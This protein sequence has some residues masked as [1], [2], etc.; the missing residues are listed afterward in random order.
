MEAPNSLLE[1]WEESFSKSLTIGK[2]P[3]VEFSD[4]PR[5]IG[6]MNVMNL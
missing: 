1:L 5:T 3:I 2:S 4:I 6:K